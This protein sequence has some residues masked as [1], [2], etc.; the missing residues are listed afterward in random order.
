MKVVSRF[1]SCV[2]TQETASSSLSYLEA[3]KESTILF[4]ST[5]EES[6]LV[7]QRQFTA[8]LFSAFS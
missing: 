3:V 2:I 4:Y 6:Q 7:T 8:H 1:I 5:F